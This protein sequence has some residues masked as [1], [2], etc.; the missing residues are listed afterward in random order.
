M[1]FAIGIRRVLFFLYFRFYWRAGGGG[2]PVFPAALFTC[3]PISIVGIPIFIGVYIISPIRPGANCCILRATFPL[4]RIAVSPYFRIAPTAAPIRQ[5]LF[6][7]SIF[8]PVKT[9]CLII[10]HAPFSLLSRAY[11]YC[12]VC[13]L[14]EINSLPD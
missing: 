4:I 13:F 2:G 14:P 7:F 8:G 3:V 5:N 1:L 12:F 6:F 11:I 10:P 9:R